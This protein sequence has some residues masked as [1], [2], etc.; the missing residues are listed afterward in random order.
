MKI[1]PRSRWCDAQLPGS[2]EEPCRATCLGSTGGLAA[3]RRA[4]GRHA[5]VHA[6]DAERERQRAVSVECHAV[7]RK[8]R[9][10]LRH[11]STDRHPSS[12]QVSIRIPISVA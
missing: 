7:E 12:R 9:Y 11:E 1:A 4:L 2:A 3:G 8:Q 10:G 6:R 5:M